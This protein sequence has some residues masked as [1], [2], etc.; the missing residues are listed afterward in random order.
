[1]YFDKNFKYNL[2][3]NTQIEADDKILDYILRKCSE[4]KP[5]KKI[6]NRGRKSA[7][8]TFLIYEKLVTIVMDYGNEKII[9]G[10]IETRWWRY[11]NEIENNQIL[12]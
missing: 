2:Y 12:Q 11:K 8:F 9:T 1:M 5:Y 10:V 4:I 7:Y 3:K 6:D